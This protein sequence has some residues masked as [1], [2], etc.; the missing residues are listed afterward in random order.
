MSAIVRLAASPEGRE[1][2]TTGVR[3]LFFAGAVS[4]VAALL[5]TLRLPDV[6]LEKR[7]PR[8]RAAAA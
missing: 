8:V 7:A 1:A 4:A 3:T 5:V 6:Q 2:I